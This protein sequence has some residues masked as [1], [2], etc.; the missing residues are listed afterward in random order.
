MRESD[1]HC[2]VTVDPDADTETVELVVTF[3]VRDLFVSRLSIDAEESPVG[4]R[5]WY[6]E[7]GG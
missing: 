6:R 4:E 1:G 3:A 7:H 2:V 5:I